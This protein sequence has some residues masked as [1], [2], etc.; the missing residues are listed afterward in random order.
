MEEENNVRK[1]KGGGGG[2]RSRKDE[3]EG[4]MGCKKEEEGL[5]LGW[6]EV[7]GAPT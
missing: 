6:M 5:G 1:C 2:T 3:K 7:E 4:D